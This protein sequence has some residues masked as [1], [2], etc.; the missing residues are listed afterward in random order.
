MDPSTNDNLISI[1][2]CFHLF[3]CIHYVMES[4][5]IESCILLFYSHYIGSMFQ[6]SQLLPI[7]RMIASHHNR[8]CCSCK[9]DK[10]CPSHVIKL[11]TPQKQKFKKLALIYSL[12]FLLRSR[13]S[14]KLINRRQMRPCIGLAVGIY[15]LLYSCIL[16]S[17]WLEK[18]ITSH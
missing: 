14:C 16:G 9:A 18:K 7:W 10:M 5:L 4:L 6:S 17:G 15:I 11:Q 8:M 1:L 12:R 2:V 3:L 13:T